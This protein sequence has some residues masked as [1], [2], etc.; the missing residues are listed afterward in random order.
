MFKII[1]PVL[2]LATSWSLSAVEIVNDS[3]G[4]SSIFY[5]KFFN[6]SCTKEQAF[7]AIADIQHYPKV[8]SGI[9]TVQITGGKPQDFLANVG[10]SYSFLLKTSFLFRVQLLSPEQIIVRATDESLKEKKSTC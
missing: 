4:K 5:H 10:I 9:S 8:V 3:E 7:K 6:F 2:F 1:W